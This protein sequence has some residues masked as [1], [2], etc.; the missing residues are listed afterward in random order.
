MRGKNIGF[1][2]SMKDPVVWRLAGAWF[3]SCLTSEPAKYNFDLAA[4]VIND[5]FSK[6]A[7]KHGSRMAKVCLECMKKI[8]SVKM[9]VYN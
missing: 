9:K 5:S 6:A 4:I 1:R 8:C 7:L 3:A 2:S